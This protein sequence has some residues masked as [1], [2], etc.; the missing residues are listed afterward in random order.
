MYADLLPQRS[1]PA[2]S[3]L[4]ADSDF[5]GVAHLRPVDDGLLDPT[6]AAHIV[7]ELTSTIREL[8]DHHR[9]TEVHLLLRCPYP[10]AV[11]L[12]RS[13][14]TLTV[15]LYEWEDSD[16]ADHRGPRYVPSL[17]LRSG[18]GGSSIHRVSA[19]PTPPT[20]EAT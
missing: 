16:D 19:P 9:T 11:L 18:A 5:A 10:I 13:L 1:D 8:A 2:F 12:G 20:T 17:V 3:D 7:G 4:V 6:S 14:N 15:H